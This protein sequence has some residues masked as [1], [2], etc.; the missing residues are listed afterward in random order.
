MTAKPTMAPQDAK[1]P[2]P[3]RQTKKL[4]GRNG[5]RKKNNI[6]VNIQKAASQT[7]FIYEV[8]DD[9]TLAFCP[10]L[11]PLTFDTRKIGLYHLPSAPTLIH[12]M[13]SFNM[14]VA[15]RFFEERRRRRRGGWRHG[16]RRRSQSKTLSSHASFTRDDDDDNEIREHF[17]N[18][19]NF[20]LHHNRHPP[21]QPLNVK[22]HTHHTEINKDDVAISLPLQSLLL[23][24]LICPKS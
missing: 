13:E 23:P 1:R 6:T 16:R 22:R 14:V 8:E 2:L 15:L 3:L 19:L 24:Q 10:G 7:V 4:Q 21:P 9:G 20:P 12:L 17:I 5:A 11:N 18:T